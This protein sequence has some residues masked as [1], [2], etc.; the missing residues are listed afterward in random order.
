VC[1]GVVQHAGM[2]DQAD[3]AQLA[4]VE[5]WSATAAGAS[6]LTHYKC[7]MHA[8]VL[9]VLRVF[10]GHLLP[11]LEMCTCAA[12]FVQT[13]QAHAVLTLTSEREQSSALL[14]LAALVTQI[15]SRPC[16]PMHGRHSIA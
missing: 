16:I 8:C 6:M 14:L 12:V 13:S 4:N 15:S 9:T 3:G 7:Q 5:L 10:G 2:T 11:S 1:R